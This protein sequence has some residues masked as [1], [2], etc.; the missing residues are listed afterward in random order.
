MVPPPKGAS[1]VGK[2]W[3]YVTRIK[4]VRVWPSC[5]EDQK[6]GS[7]VRCI[8]CRPG[9]FDCRKELCIKGGGHCFWCY[10]G[11]DAPISR[12]INTHQKRGVQKLRN[13]K[14]CRSLRYTKEELEQVPEKLCMLNDVGKG[15]CK[16]TGILLL[17]IQ[18]NWRVLVLLLWLPISC[19]RNGPLLHKE[20]GRICL[21]VSIEGTFKSVYLLCLPFL[22]N[23]SNS[24]S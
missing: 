12:G 6:P 20:G 3:V 11:P 17:S 14:Y 8:T 18:H 4:F 24:A 16:M 2:N 10:F 5:S 9:G 21:V 22:R 15:G 7:A 19:I 1:I 13:N 23:C